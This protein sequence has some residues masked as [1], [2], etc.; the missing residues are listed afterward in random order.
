[1]AD[2]IKISW[3]QWLPIFGWRIVAVVESADDIPQ[4]LP[5]NGA[6]LVG[7]RAQPKWI[8]F[9]C[10]CRSGHRIIL[11]TDKLRLPY[12]ITNVQGPL[13]LS[14]SIDYV[15]PKRRCHYFILN[16]RI[17]WIPERKTR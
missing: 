5:R 11:N 9:D 4:R 3:W 1:M 15:H 8:A 12:W 14:P 2:S 16:G 7:S 6:V 13:T 10:P 17:E